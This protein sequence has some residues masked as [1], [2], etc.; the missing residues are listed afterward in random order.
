MSWLR[1]VFCFLL[2]CTNK[3][4]RVTCENESDPLSPWRVEQN[5]EQKLHPPPPHPNNNKTQTNN[6]KTK[7]QQQQQWKLDW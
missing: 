6:N 2:L 4:A 5:A 7:K 3:Q 1:W